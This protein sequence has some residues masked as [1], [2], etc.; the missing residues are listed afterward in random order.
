MIAPT[1]VALAG[2]LAGPA[3]APAAKQPIAAVRAPPGAPTP[4][5]A[6]GRHAGLA[7]RRV[8]TRQPVVALTF[9]A[10]ATAGT[11]ERFDRE[12]LEILERERV[13][14]TV[15]MTGR[16]IEA[17]PD[18]ARA[19]AAAPGIEVGNHAFSH[20][21][22]SPLSAAE[23]GR[24]ID[25]AEAHIRRLGRRSVAFR[26]PFGD[27]SATLLEAARARGLP[28]VLWDV[29]S[30]DAGGHFRP[31]T[32][33]ESVTARVR[34]GSIVVFHINGRGPRTKE[35]LPAIIDRLRRRG[36]RFVRVSELLALDDARVEPAA[37]A[38]YRPRG[39]AVEARKA[40]ARGR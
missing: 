16:W 36:L 4:G 19:L 34:P 31:A 23:A 33:I 28:V 26:P 27:W 29:V 18:G 5:G 8:R 39:V 25:E 13:E 15:F 35:A 40:G 24:E 10:C 9:D 21:R 38:T 6:A 1:A 22:F 14:A 3:P 17:H 37:P 2:V 32:M 11:P 30:L 12:V 7:V 20:H